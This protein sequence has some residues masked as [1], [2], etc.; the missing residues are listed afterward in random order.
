MPAQAQPRICLLPPQQLAAELSGHHRGLRA[1]LTWQPPRINADAVGGYHVDRTTWWPGDPPV[2]TR[3]TA[4]PVTDCRFTDEAVVPDQVNEYRVVAVNSH[5]PAVVSPPSFPAA[6]Y[7]FAFMR[8]DDMLA[9]LQA[10]AADNP[11]I[12]RLVD[13]RPSAGRGLRI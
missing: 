12:C 4:A 7:G 2:T 1:E 10:L 5:F 3:L 6:V 9:D 13:A 11:D 8:Y